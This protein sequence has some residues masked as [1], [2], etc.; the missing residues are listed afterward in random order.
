MEHSS[1][2]SLGLPA[3]FSVLDLLWRGRLPGFWKW[4][5]ITL[6]IEPFVCLSLLILLPKTHCGSWSFESLPKE[7]E[8]WEST[9]KKTLLSCL[10]G[11]R[12]PILS[13]GFITFDRWNSTLWVPKTIL[14]HHLYSHLA[15]PNRSFVMHKNDS[16]NHSGYRPAPSN[17]KK[18][19]LWSAQVLNRA[20][21]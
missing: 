4:H 16:L 18:W 20:Q 12:I 5:K 3:G 2:C 8:L 10:H 15:L 11:I 17:W 19:Q 21:K 1:A 14:C 13:Q 6:M 7:Q 9:S